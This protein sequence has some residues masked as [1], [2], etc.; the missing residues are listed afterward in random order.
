MPTLRTPRQ[1]W[2]RLCTDAF[3]ATTSH[4]IYCPLCRKSGASRRATMRASRL[5][6][7]TQRAA[8]CTAHARTKL[9]V[10]QIVSGRAHPACSVCGESR[11]RCLSVDHAFLDGHT[12]RETTPQ[13]KL[14]SNLVSGARD[15][16]DLRVLCMNCQFLSASYGPDSQT[17]SG[18][19]ARETA[20][21]EKELKR[22]PKGRIKNDTNTSRR[23]RKT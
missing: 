2:C 21:V 3:A 7:E 22:L 11:F 4:Q 13:W 23:Q 19:A 20:W 10:L 1:A 17:W 14:F 6:V 16:F 12:E 18:Q 8:A 9:T 5:K 15:P